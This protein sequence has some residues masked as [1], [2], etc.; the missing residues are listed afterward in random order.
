MKKITKIFILI[1]SLILVNLLTVI[2]LADVPAP[3]DCLPGQ[4]PKTTFCTP[5]NN[6]NKDAK[7]NGDRSND[8]KNNITGATNPED[9]SQQKEVMLYAALG[10]AVVV[11]TG[12]SIAVLIKIRSR[13]IKK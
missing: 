10:G 13:S 1:T 6:K 8:N 11:V 3:P 2:A 4:D 9:T 5:A 12:V 7:N